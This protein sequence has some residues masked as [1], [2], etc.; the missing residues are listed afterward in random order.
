MSE[1]LVKSVEPT[2]RFSSKG[3]SGSAVCTDG[4][5]AVGMVRY[6]GAQSVLMKQDDPYMTPMNLLLEDMN[7]HLAGFMFRSVVESLQILWFLMTL[8]RSS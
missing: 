6:G 3:D 5:K 7:R 1:C 4:Q 2:T 8:C